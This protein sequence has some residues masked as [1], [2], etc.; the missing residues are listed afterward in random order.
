MNDLLRECQQAARRLR[1]APGFTLVTLLTLG[2]GIGTCT[3][4]YTVVYSLLLQPL[5]YPEPD[6]IVHLW[7]VNARGT[8]HAFSDP[9]Y[10]DVREGSRSFAALAQYAQ[11]TV[12]VVGGSTPVRVKLASVSG[13]FPDV[14]GTRP[15]IGRTFLADE[16]RIGGPPAVL[17]SYGYWQQMLGGTRD[18]G[19]RPLNFE[20]RSYTI[21][22]VM[23]P[24]F[25]FPAGAD[26]WTP[27][28]LEERYASRTAHNWRVVGRLAPTVSLTQARDDVHAIARRLKAQYGDDTWMVDGAVVSPA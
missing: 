7:Q 5:P 2:L 19:A 15:V 3:A 4:I 28:E 24:G 8:Q 27:R 12:S 14:F 10:E 26:L 11:W 6:L 23:P 18:L 17:V 13:S 9:N 16:R 20:Q 1:R 21:V 22:G 25:D